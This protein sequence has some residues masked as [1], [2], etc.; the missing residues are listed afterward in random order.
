[1]LD[2][3]ATAISPADPAPEPGAG[4]EPTGLRRVAAGTLR[5]VGSRGFK[6]AF[7]LVAAGLGAY[8]VISQWAQF[9]SGVADLG[10]ATIL[11]A[12]ASVLLAWFFNMLVWRV[13]L[14]ASGSRLPMRGAA[15]VFFVGQLGKYVPGSVWSVLAQMELGRAYKVPRERSGTVAVLTMVVSLAVALLVTLVSLP[16][17][18]GRA[19]AGYAWAFLFVPVL[20]ACL[21]PRVLNPAID[22]LLRTARRPAP[23][24][25]LRGPAVAA[26]MGLG[27]AAWLLSGVHIWLIAVRLGAPAG[28]TLP[29]AIGIFA[30]AWSVGFLIVFA[31]AGAGVREVILIAA[32]TPVLH[33]A[34][35][36]T[37]VAL[38]SRLVTVLADLIAAG[39]A[40]WVGRLR[41]PSDVE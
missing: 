15:R 19:T 38:V 8:A 21:H 13:L 33:S 3:A 1:M 22:R 25:P 31:P 35:L 5:A 26:A 20:L 2:P 12:L 28:H 6:A 40:A 24:Q 18:G 27:L 16:F 11:E 7:V 17:L 30:F 29:L 4:P 10:V 37:V 9:K 32:L 41:A 34:G 39:V 14:T 36:A 23:E